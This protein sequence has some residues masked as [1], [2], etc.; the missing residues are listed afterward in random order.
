MPEEKDYT[1]YVT[2]PMWISQFFHISAENEEA[3]RAKFELYLKNLKDEDEPLDMEDMEYV[4]YPE[5]DPSQAMIVY[6]EES[7]EPNG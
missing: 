3:A 5:V 4:K 1:I 2:A 7:W 6:I